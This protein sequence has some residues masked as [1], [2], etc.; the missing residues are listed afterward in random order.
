MPIAIHDLT[1]VYSGG[2]P[3]E[4]KALDGISLSIEDGEF[5]GVVGP[6]GAGKSTL[7]QHLNG[8]LKPTSGSVVLDGQDLSSKETNLKAV[9]HRVGIIFQYPEHQLFE[10]TVFED[11]AFG[12]RNLDLDEAE[13]RSRVAESLGLVGLEEALLERSPF[14]LSGGQMRRVAIAGVLAMKPSVLVLDEPTAGLDPRGREEILGHIARLHR[15]QKL[16]VILVTH[17][18]EDVARLTNRVVV[19]NQGRVALEGSTRHVFSQREALRSLGL[20]PPDVSEVLYRLKEM[21]IRVRTDVLTVEEAAEA[22]LAAAGEE[23]SCS[24]T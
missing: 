22:I 20:A 15:E 7:I 18:M 17:N 11:V 14:E 24:K 6:T 8:L 10:E 21:G 1:F 4:M 16:T 12:P 9:R 5:V 3:Y 23:P 2:T 13:V 19:L